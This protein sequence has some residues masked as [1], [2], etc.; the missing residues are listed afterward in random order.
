MGL[1]AQQIIDARDFILIHLKTE[2]PHAA[3]KML[4]GKLP[5]VIQ[6]HVL[7]CAVFF[8]RII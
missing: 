2:P 8:Y 5:A 3:R 4:S 1:H 6:N 7:R